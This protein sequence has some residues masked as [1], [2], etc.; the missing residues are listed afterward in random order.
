MA[1]LEKRMY[2]GELARQVLEN[3]AFNQAFADIKQEY[4]TA[5]MNSHAVDQDAREE[6]W[7]L[8][9]LADKLKITLEGMLTDGKMA[10]Q[11]REYQARLLAQQ[12]AQGVSIG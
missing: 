1:T 5:W 11:E 12:R 6:I 2:D 3:D 10:N 8:I 4:T 7:K 9:K